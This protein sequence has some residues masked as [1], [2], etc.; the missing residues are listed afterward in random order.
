MK[1]SELRHIIK[2]EIRYIIRETKYNEMV[3]K[4]NDPKLKRIS[5]LPVDD[6]LKELHKEVQIMKERGVWY[7]IKDKGN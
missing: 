3:N 6:M 5:T 7:D 2:E 1:K 4:I